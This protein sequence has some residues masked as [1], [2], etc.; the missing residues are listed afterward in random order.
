MR[1]H[2]LIH[3]TLIISVM[4]VTAGNQIRA[5]DVDQRIILLKI[6]QKWTLWINKFT[7]APKI[8]KLVCTDQQ[9]YI[10]NNKTVHMKARH[11]RYKCLWNICLPVHKYLEEILETA[12]TLPIGVYTWVRL[13]T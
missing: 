8:L 10:R 9:K 2:P 11:R 5:S 3:A 4:N 7:R 1:N 13:V 12:H 6:F